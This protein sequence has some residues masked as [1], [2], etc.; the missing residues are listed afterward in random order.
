MTT[1]STTCLNCHS[2]GVLLDENI[3]AL[4]RLDPH[5]DAREHDRGT[6]DF[7]IS[8]RVRAA[9]RQKCSFA[10]LFAIAPRESL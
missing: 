2:P 3:W 4:V 1:G 8:M 6:L 7:S 5:G 9:I 10:H